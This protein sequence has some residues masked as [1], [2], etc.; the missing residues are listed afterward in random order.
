MTRLQSAHILSLAM[1]EGDGTTITSVLPQNILTLPPLVTSYVGMKQNPHLC[2]ITHAHLHAPPV[3]PLPL[4]W[5]PLTLRQSVSGYGNA[6]TLKLTLASQ[7][8]SVGHW[9]FP[10]RAPLPTTPFFSFQFEF[11]RSQAFP[12]VFSFPFFSFVLASCFLLQPL[13]NATVPTTH[14]LSLS[15]IKLFF[16]F[17]F[18]R[19]PATTQSHVFIF[20]SSL[21][22]FIIFFCHS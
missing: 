1:F 16:L 10:S 21:S 5:V 9:R 18:T 4:W 13:H 2:P 19:S 20:S 7:S 15:L 14:S 17:K 3:I 22:L 8:F 6:C 12:F 11:L